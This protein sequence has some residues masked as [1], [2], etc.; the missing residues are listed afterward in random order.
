MTTG[1]MRK[2][3]ATQ[4]TRTVHQPHANRTLTITVCGTRTI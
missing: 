4:R 1:I 2:S 3:G